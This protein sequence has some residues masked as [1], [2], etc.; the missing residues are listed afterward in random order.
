MKIWLENYYIEK[1]DR[2]FLPQLRDF[3]SITMAEHMESAGNAI[4]KLIDKRVNL[5]Y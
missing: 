1:E 5:H 3:A 4:I 2:P